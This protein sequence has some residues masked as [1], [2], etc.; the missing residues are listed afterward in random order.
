M[1]KK[2]KKKV[3]KSGKL[4]V[5]LLD[6]AIRVVNTEPE[7]PDPTNAVETSAHAQVIALCKIYANANNDAGLTNVLRSIVSCTKDSIVERLRKEAKG[8]VV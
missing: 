4:T 7:L 6:T 2:I 3:K 1:K 5:I 8:L